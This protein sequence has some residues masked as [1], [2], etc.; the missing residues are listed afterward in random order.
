MVRTSY[1]PPWLRRGG[2]AINQISR[3]LLSRRRRGGS[4]KPSNHRKLNQPPRPLHQRRLRGIFITVASTP[5]WP[6]RGVPVRNIS[7][8]WVGCVKYIP[9]VTTA[10][11]N[12]ALKPVVLL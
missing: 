8:Q 4:F 3:S 12:L 9:E 7:P 2:C 5:P 6:R 1:S 10:K 11:L